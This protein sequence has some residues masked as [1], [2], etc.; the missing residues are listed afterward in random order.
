MVKIKVKM[1]NVNK[2]PLATKPIFV[3]TLFSNSTLKLYQ[4][5]FKPQKPL[6]F[7][8]HFLFRRNQNNKSI[9]TSNM[10]ISEQVFKKYITCRLPETTQSRNMPTL[11]CN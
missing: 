11:T 4:K 6:A 9:L 5:N 8:L 1:P 10:K 3:Q 2:T 7:L